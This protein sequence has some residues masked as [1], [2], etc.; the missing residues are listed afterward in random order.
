VTRATTA[1]RSQVSVTKHLYFI[2]L[3][4]DVGI[5]AVSVCRYNR[6]LFAAIIALIQV[7]EWAIM[8]KTTCK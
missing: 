7:R 6:V 1:N 2:N 3:F 8:R 4:C 5:V